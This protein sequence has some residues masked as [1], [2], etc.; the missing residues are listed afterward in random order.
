MLLTED[1]AEEVG[2][3]AGED[4]AAAVA[5]D[6]EG[7]GVGVL[8]MTNVAAPS[9][10]TLLLLLMELVG[11][12]A[13]LLLSSCSLLTTTAVA[14][15]VVVDNGPALTTC[16]GMVGADIGDGAKSIGVELMV[17]GECGMTATEV[18]LMS[19]MMLCDGGGGGGGT[20]AV[21]MAGVREIGLFL[22][23]S[24]CSDCLCLRKCRSMLLLSEKFLWQT[25]H[26]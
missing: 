14:T 13:A 22:V 8:R 18:S 16:N 26:E 20:G 5:D 15:M 12:D 2:V 25:G 1:G 23:A 17:T 7:E 6:D 10:C 4:G 11:G 21:L 3:V 24:I 19:S 9:C